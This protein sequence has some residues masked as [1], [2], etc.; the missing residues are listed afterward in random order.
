MRGVKI[1]SPWPLVAL[2]AAAAMAPGARLGPPAS[3]PPVLQPLA[4]SALLT[5]EGAVV[6]DALI[7]RVRSN[8]GAT[9]VTVSDFSVA[10]DGNTVAVAPGVDGSWRVA[11]PPRMGASEGTLAVTVMHDGIRELLQATIPWPKAAAP[12]PA[13]A[14]A[15]APAAAPTPGAGGTGVHRQIVWWILNIAIVLIAAL[16]LSRRRS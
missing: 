4:H 13:P 10:L 6:A 11:L 7:L 15:R 9:P 14:A 2:L 12:A 16:A 1:L 8:A 3:P 5:L